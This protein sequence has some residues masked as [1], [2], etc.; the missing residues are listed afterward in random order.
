MTSKLDLKAITEYSNEFSQKICN[1]FFSKKNR[2]TG[3]EI[4][5]ISPIDQVNVFTIK[6]LYE[7]WKSATEKFKSPF[8]D[9][10]NEKVKAALKDFMNIVSQN[11]SVGEKDLQPLVSK[12]TAE[13][14]ALALNPQEYLDGV[15]RDLPDFKC[16][17]ADINLIKKY[18]RLN[19]EILNS[20]EEKFGKDDF[21]FT[22]QALNWLEEVMQ[23]IKLNDQDRII[24]EFN[25]VLSCSK[26]QFYKNKS[27]YKAEEATTESAS[28][29]DTIVSQEAKPM[30]N[31]EVEWKAPIIEKPSEP[32]VEKEAPST[33]NEQ[34]QSDKPTVNDHLKQS[35]GQTLVD[36]H[37]N[38]PV[39]NL[40]GSISLNQKFVFINKLFNG[41]SAAYSETLTIL[42]NC[43][44]TDEAL[45]L[46]KYKYAPKYQWN[47]NGDEADELMDILRRKA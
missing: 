3:E 26:V 4:L 24:S 32:V 11:I 21:V 6:A 17:V 14:L 29:F 36:I 47:L 31:K 22:N 16:T 19:S 20:I 28:F 12:A 44:D 37:Q 23:N 1:N 34:Y 7:N 15:I 45:Q 30:E 39:K 2:I 27:M 38:A 40:A 9:F 33:L 25:A 5:N 41:D 8:F 13:T 42:E 43:R 18:T 35:E 10:E 46:L